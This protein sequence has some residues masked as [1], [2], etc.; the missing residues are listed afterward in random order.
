MVAMWVLRIFSLQLNKRSIF[1]THI[2]G[3]ESNDTFL[4]A[5]YLR[6]SAIKKFKNVNYKSLMLL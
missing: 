4:N 3:T 5:I 2:H 6:N 1:I